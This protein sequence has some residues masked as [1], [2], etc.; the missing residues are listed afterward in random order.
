MTSCWPRGFVFLLLSFVK[1]F[2][3]FY[4]LIFCFSGFD[5]ATLE[6]KFDKMLQA[7]FNESNAKPSTGFK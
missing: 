6:M 1:N 7:R 4:F 5:F 2:R 3:G